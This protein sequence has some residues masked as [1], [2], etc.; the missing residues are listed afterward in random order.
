MRN[1]TLAAKNPYDQ[2]LSSVLPHNVQDGLMDRMRGSASTQSST[3]EFINMPLCI[4]LYHGTVKFLP[5]PAR[6]D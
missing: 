3:F 5:Y 4:M 2:F 6:Q 1:A